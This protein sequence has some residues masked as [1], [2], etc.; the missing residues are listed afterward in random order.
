MG[1]DPPSF[2]NFKWAS[3]FAEAGQ[4]INSLEHLLVNLAGAP[5]NKEAAQAVRAVETDLRKI[6]GDDDTAVRPITNLGTE[7]SPRRHKLWEL[8]LQIR[9]NHAADTQV[10]VFSRRFGCHM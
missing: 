1:I 7:H 9:W 4:P 3:R 2:S 5:V 10:G 6:D 8:L